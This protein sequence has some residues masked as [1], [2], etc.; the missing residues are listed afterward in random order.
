MLDTAPAPAIPRGPT[1]IAI[2][3]YQAELCLGAVLDE[4]RRSLE[5]RGLTEVPILVVDDGS[6]DATLEVAKARHAKVERHPQ[7]RGKGAALKTALTWA[8]SEGLAALVTADAD[9]QHPADSILE[10]LTAPCPASSLVLG[11]RSLREAAAPRSHRF[12]NG[13]SNRFLSWFTGQTLRD[14]QCGL[15][16]YPVDEVLRLGVTDVGYAF[17]AEVILR[18][19]RAQIP[20]EQMP[21]QVVYPPRERRVSHFRNVRDPA[22]IVARVVQTLLESPRSPT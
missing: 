21:I 5:K 15:R 8:K 16:R 18:A 17:E 10:I 14:T 6:T 4:L 1:G 7:N 22:R 2:P 9:G 20:I 12:S 11:I 3:A 13:I 19:A